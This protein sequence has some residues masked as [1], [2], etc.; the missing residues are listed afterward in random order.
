ML[1]NERQKFVRGIDY[2]SPA[3]HLEEIRQCIQF[4]EEAI[5]EKE[6]VPPNF[7]RPMDNIS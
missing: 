6:T 1:T 3:G 5:T 4:I 2:G 7:I